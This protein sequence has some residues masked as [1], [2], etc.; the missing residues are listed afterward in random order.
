MRFIAFFFEALPPLFPSPVMRALHQFSGRDWARL[1]PLAHA[2][3]Q[4][5]NDAWMQIYRRR[6][7]EGY[8]GF[9]RE[10]AALQDRP[11]ALVIAF[12]QPWAL[13]WLLS[14]AKRHLQDTT[15]LVMDNSRRLEQRIEIER[16]CRA[17]GIHYLALPPNATRHV[18]RSHGMAM[19][20]AFYNVV[21]RIRPSVFA[22]LD[23][24][25]IPLRPLSLAARLGQQPLYGMRLTRQWAWQLWAGYCMYSYA[26]VG[27]RPLNFLYDF[28]RGLDTGG[29]NW[30]HLYR[31]LDPA[32]LRFAHS[33]HVAIK[34]L[35]GGEPVKVQ[36]ID[37]A[38]FHIGGISYNQNFPAK[39]ALCQHL[40]QAF[41]EGATWEQMLA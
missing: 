23:H 10:T 40:A 31:D 25:L 13:N 30:P 1:T 11:I 7:P 35:A 8:A 9:L 16:V 39:A 21:R 34:N 24:D 33:A 38:W 14:M 19:N 41:E 20:W 26:Q 32:T 18:N 27:E 17:H 5:R 22:F 36:W 12:E 15:V 2:F 37:D 3:K 6:T 28:S 4:L 29:R